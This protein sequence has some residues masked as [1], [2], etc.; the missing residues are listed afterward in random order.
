MVSFFIGVSI[1]T[2]T[3]GVEGEESIACLPQLALLSKGS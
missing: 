3:L 2:R 1:E